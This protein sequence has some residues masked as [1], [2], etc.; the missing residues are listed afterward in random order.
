M[1]Q[2]MVRSYKR[3]GLHASFSDQVEEGQQI[4]EKTPDV[5]QIQTE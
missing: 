2:A 5:F 1:D 3:L 4:G